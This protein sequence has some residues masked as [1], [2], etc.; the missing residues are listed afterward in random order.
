MKMWHLITVASLQLI[1]ANVGADESLTVFH[2]GSAGDDQV[3]TIHWMTP[4]PIPWPVW[5][6]VSVTVDVAEDIN[7]SHAST[8]EEEFLVEIVSAMTCWHVKC[9]G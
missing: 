3:D 6:F 1:V 5:V 2:Q 8:I 9:A 4:R 7:S